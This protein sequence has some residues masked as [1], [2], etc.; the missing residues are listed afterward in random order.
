MRG[1]GSARGTFRGEIAVALLLLALAM[2]VLVPAG[3]MPSVDGRA[4]TLCTGTGAVEAWVAD[5]GTIH[6]KAPG[7]TGKGAEPCVFAGLGAAL[8]TPDPPVAPPTLFAAPVAA[9]LAVP[10]VAIGRGLAA[11]PP[12]PTGPPAI[13]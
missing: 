8:L 3:W 11:P 13:R 2:R 6:K 7:E 4:I 1:R 9:V 12:P 10:A 5:D